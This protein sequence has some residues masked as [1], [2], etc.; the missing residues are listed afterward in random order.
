MTGQQSI[1]VTPERS[2]APTLP[3][4]TTQSSQ[5]N[6]LVQS[7]GTATLTMAEVNRMAHRHSQD[8]REH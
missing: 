1:Q 5:G 8:T 7:Q 2:E 4:P 6:P 3:L